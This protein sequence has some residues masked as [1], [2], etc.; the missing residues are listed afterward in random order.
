M[1]GR[2]DEFDLDESDDLDDD[3]PGYDDGPDVDPDL[4]MMP[5]PH[6][7]G[8]IYDDSERCPHCGDYLS[9]DDVPFRPPLWIVVGVG[10]CL[11]MIARW[12]VRF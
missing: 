1:R 8:T 10:V 5:C 4:V 2:D 11:V 7:F 9:K 12:I 3:G 6:C